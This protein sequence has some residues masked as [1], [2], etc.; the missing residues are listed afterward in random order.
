MIRKI[1]IVGSLISI[2]AI[3]YLAMQYGQPPS[4]SFAEAIDKTQHTSESDPASKVMVDVVIT[5]ASDLASIAATD[6]A[7][8]GFSIQYT[9]TAPTS[10]LKTGMRARFVGHVHGGDTPIFH[11]TQVLFP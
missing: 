10:P 11:A 8:A 1:I 6:N 7:G 5:D 9:G 3:M 4:V 2:P